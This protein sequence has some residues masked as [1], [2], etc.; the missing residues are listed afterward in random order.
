[1]SHIIVVTSGKGGTGKTA[2]SLYTGAALAR[3]GRRVLLIEMDAG[4]RGLDIAMGVSDKTAFDMSDVLLGRME[5]QKAVVECPFAPGFYL[6]PASARREA[7]PQQD[8]LS[9]MIR[10]AGGWYDMILLDSPAGLGKGFDVS[11]QAADSAILVV[12]PDPIAIRDAAATAQ[13]IFEHGKGCRLLINRVPPR[14]RQL[15]VPDLD[16][17]I[18]TVGVQLVGA[19]FEDA[20]LQ[21][22]MAQGKS[23]PFESPAAQEFENIA[24]RLE[25]EYVPLPL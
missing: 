10:Q 4:L 3:K 15:L 13:L 24:S 6:L 1:M 22:A 18:D 20:Q 2:A 17:I 23:L 14:A 8:G 19:I 25:G 9:K 7:S 12:T 21:T 5:L 16:S 11:L